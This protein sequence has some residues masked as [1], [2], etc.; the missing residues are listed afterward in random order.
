MNNKKKSIKMK[1][2]SLQFLFFIAIIIFK[3]LN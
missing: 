3:Y 1:N 2:I